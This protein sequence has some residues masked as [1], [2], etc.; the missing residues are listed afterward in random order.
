MA[1]AVVCATVMADTVDFTFNNTVGDGN[2]VPGDGVVFTTIDDGFAP[3][4]LMQSVLIKSTDEESPG[5]WGYSSSFSK[6]FPFAGEYEATIELAYM[7]TPMRQL[8]AKKITVAKPDKI[9]VANPA[10]WAGTDCMINVDYNIQFKIKAG[11]KTANL[12]LAT[13]TAEEKITRY[14]PTTGAVLRVGN[15]VSGARFNYEGAGLIKDLKATTGD[16][17]AFAAV[18]NGTILNHVKQEIRINYLRGD[19]KVIISPVLGTF[20]IVKKKSGTNT[21]TY[22]ITEQ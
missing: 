16:P 15:W 21:V 7:D 9:V 6:N 5:N 20:D 19:G 14:D 10:A 3:L 4:P 13:T 17:V 2:I 18:P 8:P 1:A 11:S 22:I 12:D